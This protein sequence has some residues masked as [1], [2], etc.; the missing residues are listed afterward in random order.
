[1]MDVR[2][3]P[4]LVHPPS[5]DAITTRPAVL[6]R[7]VPWPASE[8]PGNLDRTLALE[9]THHVRHGILGRDTQ[10]PVHMVHPQVPFPELRLL[11]SF[12]DLPKTG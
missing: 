10:A 4:L 11:Y 3:A 2:P 5:G 1:M 9:L 7:E 6:T 12:D 8:L